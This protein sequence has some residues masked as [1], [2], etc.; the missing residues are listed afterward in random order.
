MS[1][2]NK[3]RPLYFTS[4]FH[5]SET[6]AGLAKKGLL[7]NDSEVEKRAVSDKHHIQYT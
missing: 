4:E 2:V 6:Q 1:I 7:H 3:L 5:T